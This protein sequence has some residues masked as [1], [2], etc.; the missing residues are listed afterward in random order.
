[1]NAR[2]FVDFSALFW[3]GL[4]LGVLLGGFGSCAGGYV[5]R[6]VQVEWSEPAQ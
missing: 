3:L 1:M 4:V 6:R 5:L 2:G